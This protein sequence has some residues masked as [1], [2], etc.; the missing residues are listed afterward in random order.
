[1]LIFGPKCLL[2]FC[3]LSEDQ[4]NGIT[5]VNSNSDVEK[6]IVINFIYSEIP[7]ITNGTLPRSHAKLSSNQL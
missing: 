2:I 1:M 4:T 5:L 6:Y 7:P 3:P